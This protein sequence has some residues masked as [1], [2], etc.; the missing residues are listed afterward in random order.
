MI[1][2]IS[3]EP[4][5]LQMPLDRPTLFSNRTAFHRDHSVVTVRCADGSHGMG[6]LCGEL[7]WAVGGR[8]G[9]EVAG[10]SV[11]RVGWRR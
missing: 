6:L 1:T 8:G 10:A 7:E 9:V 2:G 4:R 11:D 5:M 3:V